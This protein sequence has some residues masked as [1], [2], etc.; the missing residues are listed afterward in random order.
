MRWAL[1]TESVVSYLLAGATL[2]IISEMMRRADRR[3]VSEA[4]P[5]LRHL[6]LLFAALCVIRAVIGLLA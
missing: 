5:L 2:I 3:D 1:N 4:A 6:L